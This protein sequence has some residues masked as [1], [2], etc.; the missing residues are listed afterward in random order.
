MNRPAR[1]FAGLA[2]VVATGLAALWI[3][4]A[5][6][7]TSDLSTLENGQCPSGEKACFALGKE[8]CVSTSDPK[9]G[10]SAPSCL[11]CDVKLANAVTTCSA[12]GA[13][14]I[15]ACAAG[16]IDCNNSDIDGCEIDIGADINNCGLCGMTCVAVPHAAPVC[17]HEVC[18]LQCAD[19]FGDCD[20]K[21]S[22]GCEASLRVDPSHCGQCGTACT[23]AQTCVAGTCE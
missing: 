6:G 1:S 11:S 18:A 20:R 14:T 19:D 21:Y 10:C 2:F 3:A 23:A 13:C 15:A 5:C 17:V 9:T 16:Y 7:I 12:S 8:Q 4:S 22:N